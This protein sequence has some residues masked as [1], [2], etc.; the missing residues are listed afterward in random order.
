MWGMSINAIVVIKDEVED[1]TV[2]K[3][4]HVCIKLCM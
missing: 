2:L 1:N 4:Y 3:I